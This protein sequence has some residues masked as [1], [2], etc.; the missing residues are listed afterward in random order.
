MAD[1]IVTTGEA[2]NEPQVAEEFDSTEQEF[3][4]LY[5]RCEEESQRMKQ[6]AT[7]IQPSAPQA[8]EAMRQVAGNVLPLLQEVIATCGGALQSLEDLAEEGPAGEGLGE[9]DA[10]DFARTILANNKI[11]AE[12]LTAATDAELIERLTA[13]KTMN[14][15]MM[16]RLL[17]LADLSEQELQ[18]ALAQDLD[19]D[20]TPNDEAN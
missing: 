4:A 16:E 14:E 7:S 20:E 9:E 6:L 11:I 1:T 2:V 13:V 8:A 5:D 12:L 10:L 19:S 15:E 3:R 18:Q 17:E